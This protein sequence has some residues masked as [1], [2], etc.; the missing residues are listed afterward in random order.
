[1]HLLHRALWRLRISAWQ[2]DS[3]QNLKEHGWSGQQSPLNL[4]H[5]YKSSLHYSNIGLLYQIKSLWKIFCVLFSSCND[6]KCQC[7]WQILFTLQSCFF[8]SCTCIPTEE[9]I[10]YWTLPYKNQRLGVEWICIAVLSSLLRPRM[11]CARN[12]KSSLMNLFYYWKYLYH[13]S[14][15]FS[16]SLQWLFIF[17]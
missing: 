17:M 9:I 13:P 16:V 2:Q 11:L 3:V 12:H 10:V 7:Q 14:L 6:W 15:H 4:L 5:S 1:M 8:P